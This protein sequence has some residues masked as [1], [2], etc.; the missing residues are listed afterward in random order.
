MTPAPTAAPAVALTIWAALAL[1]AAGEYGRARRPPAAWARPVWLAG[2]A[3]YLAHI[4]AAFGLHH[5]WS[6]AAAYAHTAARTEALVGLH[7]GGGLWVN[8]AFTALWVGEGLWWRL[9]P[10]HHAR[11]AAVWTRIVRGGFLFMI[12]NGAVIF[13]SGPRRLLGIAVVAALLWIWRGAD[14]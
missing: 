3:A 12:A 10:A 2:G 5:D 4:A 11:R 13:V 1:Y 8:H 14:D 9:A 6:H 7:W